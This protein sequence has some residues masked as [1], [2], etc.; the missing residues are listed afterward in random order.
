MYF[1]KAMAD[2]SI[3]T[4]VALLLIVLFIIISSSSCN[5]SNNTHRFKNRKKKD[6]DCS[7]WSYN[8][9]NSKLNY[10][11]KFNVC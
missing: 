8:N 4:K 1:N 9:C 2:K 3:Q 11:A 6:C 7:E 10:L 5:T